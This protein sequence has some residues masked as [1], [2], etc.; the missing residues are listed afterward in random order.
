MNIVSLEKAIELKKSGY[1]QPMPQFGQFWYGKTECGYE[2]LVVTHGGSHGIAAC[3]Q[4]S[5]GDYETMKTNEYIY[6]PC[7]CE[8]DRGGS[9]T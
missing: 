4:D 3:L 6:A 8:V 5:S 9:N 7:M 1:P 2:L